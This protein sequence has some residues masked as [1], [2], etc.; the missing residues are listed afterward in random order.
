M[1]SPETSP[2]SRLRDSSVTTISD[3]MP[4]KALTRSSRRWSVPWA[5]VY[6]S[7]RAVTGWRSA[8]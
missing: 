8:W 4:T 5:I 1:C 3:R 6:R 7:A 2:A